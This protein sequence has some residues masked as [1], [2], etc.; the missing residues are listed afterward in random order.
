MI[1]AAQNTQAVEK[2][3]IFGGNAYCTESDIKMYEGMWSWIIKLQMDEKLYFPLHN[4]LKTSDLLSK[5]IMYS[6]Y[7]HAVLFISGCFV[8]IIESIFNN[9]TNTTTQVNGVNV[10]VS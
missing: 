3:V 10:K 2:L 8:W 1:L 5:C 9:L 4:F 7:S 6:L